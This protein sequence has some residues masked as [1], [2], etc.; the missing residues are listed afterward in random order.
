MV[1][2]QLKINT[3]FI[4]WISLALKC[5]VRLPWEPKMMEAIRFLFVLRRRAPSSSFFFLFFFFFWGKEG[6]QVRWVSG[7]KLKG[8]TLYILWVLFNS[9]N[10]LYTLF[11]YGWIRALEFNL[12]LHQKLLVFWFDDKEL[13]LGTNAIGWNS[14]NKNLKKEM[15]LSI[16][17]I[18]ILHLQA[19]FKFKYHKIEII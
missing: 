14:L 11:I 19:S 8:K 12:C 4:S 2:L 6:E 10:F 1:F 9:F 17:M 13:S 7:T 15:R 18:E 3:F 16:F 5:Y